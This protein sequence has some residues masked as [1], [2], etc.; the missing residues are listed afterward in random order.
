[1]WG[2]QIELIV[3]PQ[4]E[5]SCESALRHLFAFHL[6]L[7]DGFDALT[8]A[9]SQDFQSLSINMFQFP[10]NEPLSLLVR[11]SAIKLPPLGGFLDDHT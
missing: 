8:F 10:V 3:K 11:I 2:G 9:V 5:F 4:C 1:M 6:F 7:D